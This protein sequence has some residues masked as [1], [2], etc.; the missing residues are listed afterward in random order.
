MLEKKIMYFLLVQNLSVTAG[1]G[2][3]NCANIVYA[4]IS[5]FKQ[6]QSVVTIAK[7]TAVAEIHHLP[8]HLYFTDYISVLMP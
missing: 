4:G 1:V 8:H 5:V 3:E 6:I 2:D 7:M